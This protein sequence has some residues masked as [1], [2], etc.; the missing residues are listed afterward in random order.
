MI[1]YRG[2]LFHVF[3]FYIYIKNAPYRL[4]LD[5]QAMTQVSVVQEQLE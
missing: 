1:A 2:A 3:E 5:K 4:L